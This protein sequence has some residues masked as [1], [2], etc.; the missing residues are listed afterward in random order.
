MFKYLHIQLNVLQQVNLSCIIWLVNFH[1]WKKKIEIT[2]RS[3]LR[4]G[5]KDIPEWK[6]KKTTQKSSGLIGRHKEEN[7]KIK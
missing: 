3:K 6:N 2:L 5:V 1:K 4:P 7:E